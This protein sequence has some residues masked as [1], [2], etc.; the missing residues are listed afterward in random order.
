[1]LPDYGEDMFTVVCNVY[2]NM[3]T[4]NNYEGLLI[5]M[6]VAI[7]EFN[8]VIGR[9]HGDVKLENFLYNGT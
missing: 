2:P 9:P 4:L 5:D 7:E 8:E 1:M 6:F 3:H